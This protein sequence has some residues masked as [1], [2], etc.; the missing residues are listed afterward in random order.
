[1]ALENISALFVTRV[2]DISDADIS[3]GVERFLQSRLRS[4]RIQCRSDTGGVS[5][6][7]RVTT[8]AIAQMVLLCEVDIRLFAKQEL[9]RT[10]HSICVLL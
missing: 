2:N 5:L 7:I 9:E 6:T 10:I 1:M 4:G 3:Y 8:P